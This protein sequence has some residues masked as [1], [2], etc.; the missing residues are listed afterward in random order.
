M[1][2]DSF[3][4]PFSFWTLPPFI[5]ITSYG[6]ALVRFFFLFII[7]FVFSSH[8]FFYYCTIIRERMFSFMNID[9]DHLRWSNKQDERRNDHEWNKGNCSKCLCGIEF[10]SILIFFF[11]SASYSWKKN[12]KKK[13]KW[14]CDTQS[15]IWISWIDVSDVNR[16]GF[17]RTVRE[18]YKKS[19]NCFAL[20]W[21]LWNF[22]NW[23]SWERLQITSSFFFLCK[24][25][26]LL[27]SEA[28]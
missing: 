11:S 17:A 23:W 1:H 25:F 9:P 5:S 7:L 14:I 4:C 21:N 18:T 19:D 3:L 27:H 26:K 12:Q 15:I 6:D 8:F 13:K 22:N 28:F 16:K 24:I 2:Y 20:I 10:H